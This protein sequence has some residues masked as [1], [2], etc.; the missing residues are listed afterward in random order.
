MSLT[1]PELT[2]PNPEGGQE[3]AVCRGAG[4]KP[5]CPH[6]AHEDLVIQDRA[7]GWEKKE[8][9]SQEGAQVTRASSPHAFTFQHGTPKSA[10]IQ[11][12]YLVFPVIVKVNLSREWSGLYFL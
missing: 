9:G 8:R 2:T 6:V 4:V 1:T 5:K 12:L 7:G 3:A 11:N 10:R